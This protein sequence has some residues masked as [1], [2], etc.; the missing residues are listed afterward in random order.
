MALLN[1]ETLKQMIVGEGRVPAH[2]KLYVYGAGSSTLC[3]LYEDPG[4]T[5]Q[6]ANPVCADEGGEFD[7]VYLIDGRYRT[8][9]RTR[10]DQPLFTSVNLTLQGPM[11]YESIAE[12][13]T[14]A[15]LRADTMLCYGERRRKRTTMPGEYLT[16]VDGN[17]R[18]V[19]MHEGAEADLV[20]AGSVHVNAVPDATGFVTFEQLGAVGDGITDDRA[21]FAKASG[22]RVRSAGRKTFFIDIGAG[23]AEKYLNTLQPAAN[24]FWDFSDGSEILWNYCGAPLI[25]LP[26]ASSN[27]TFVRPKFVWDGYFPDTSPIQSDFSNGAMKDCFNVGALDVAGCAHIVTACPDDLTLDRPKFRARTPG[28]QKSIF[29]CIACRLD[30]TENARGKNLTIIAPEFDDYCMGIV[31]G[32]Y[33]DFSIG[34]N[35]RTTRY[36]DY[37]ALAAAT[38]PGHLFYISEY[39]SDRGW[40]NGHFGA[41][42]DLGEYQGSSP[43]GNGFTTVKLDTAENVRIESIYSQRPH[44]PLET[45][46]SQHVSIGSVTWVSN[47]THDDAAFLGTAAVNLVS[48]THRA[49]KSVFIG[50]VS[51]S[52]PGLA[53]TVGPS[54]LVKFGGTLSDSALPVQGI[55][56]DTLYIEAAGQSFASLIQFDNAEK[57]LVNQLTLNVSDPAHNFT[58]AEFSGNCIDSGIKQV[59]QVGT[60]RVE[61]IRME[62][63]IAVTGVTGSGTDPV[64]VTTGETHGYKSGDIVQLDAIGGVG[65]LNA[66][67]N[68]ITVL[69]PTRFALDGTDSSLIG[70]F[71]SGGT[72]TRPCDRCFIVSDETFGTSLRQGD[73]DS[74]PAG[75]VW[76]LS[77]PLSV[78]GKLANTPSGTTQTAQL[79]LREDGV[80][81]V[82]LLAIVRNNP[83][84]RRMQYWRA[85]QWDAAGVESVRHL[86]DL[87]E[88]EGAEISAMSLAI[89]G[90]VLTVSVTLSVSRKLEW[91]A[92]AT[93]VMPLT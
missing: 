5:L 88:V 41:I 92:S 14:I 35:I 13:S 75:G 74:R 34:P 93:R 78:G 17:H 81:E 46:G 69:S 72:A 65:E 33:D 59:T 61:G 87:E 4:L 43:G 56:I 29:A 80:Y 18:F 1:P 36:D 32:C 47:Q 82:S 42:Y 89:A 37:N 16:V 45:A 22:R 31:G 40:T 38:P 91:Y 53:G 49:C 62:T 77:R 57:C 39:T 50:T 15:A 23:G 66:T 6:V 25:F 76:P 73:Y 58:V 27:V 51:L 11:K 90:G 86:A 84:E 63:A 67:R 70:A 3:P 2:A 12:F 21:A 20:T 30:R 28:P 79:L 52:V 60:Q 68:P 55:R 9:M 64:E 26:R 85:L 83:T 48:S 54:A 7:L 10:N 24:T 44:G 19:V 71:T 8:E